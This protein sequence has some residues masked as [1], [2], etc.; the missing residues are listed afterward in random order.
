MTEKECPSKRQK[1]LYITWGILAVLPFFLI[2]NN[3]VW[4]DETY[5]LALIRHDYGDIIRILNTAAGAYRF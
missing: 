1:L 2:F 3:N 5:T 4:F